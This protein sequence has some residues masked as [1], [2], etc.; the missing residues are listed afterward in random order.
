MYM[1]IRVDGRTLN[2]FVIIPIR[3]NVHRDFVPVVGLETLP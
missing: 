2:A 1:H 3:W